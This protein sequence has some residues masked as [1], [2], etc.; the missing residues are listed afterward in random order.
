MFYSYNVIT[1]QIELSPIFCKYD[2]RSTEKG[3][4]P[5]SGSH[6]NSVTE[7]EWGPNAILFYFA[8]TG[9]SVKSWA[10]KGNDRDV[11]FCLWQ[12]LWHSASW[13]PFSW[14]EREWGPHGAILRSAYSFYQQLEETL[15]KTREHYKVPTACWALHTRQDIRAE[16]LME[17]PMYDRYEI[18]KADLRYRIC[19][20]N[21]PEQAS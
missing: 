18:P 2:N 21:V 20:A 8:T 15:R 11:P 16:F 19:Q 17:S 6:D 12:G 1:H 13:G 7:S 10:D 5:F 4:V 14:D 9:I 3:K